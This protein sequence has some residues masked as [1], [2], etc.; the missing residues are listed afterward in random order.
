MDAHADA[1]EQEHIP[2]RPGSRPGLDCH[3]RAFWLRH[4]LP[5]RRVSP[6]NTPQPQLPVATADSSSLGTSGREKPQ[7]A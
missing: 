1:L 5:L 7:Y 4:G 3:V 2:F 6:P